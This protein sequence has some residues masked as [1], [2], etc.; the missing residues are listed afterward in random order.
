MSSGSL[1]PICFE[2]RRFRGLK[3]DVGWV[4]DAFGKEPIPT[5]ITASVHDHHE[6]FQG[7]GGLQYESRGEMPLTKKGSEILRSMQEQYGENKGKEVFYA[8]ANKG[9]ISGVHDA[10]ARDLSPG[11]WSVLKR[12]WNEWLSEEEAE[13]EHEE[14]GEDADALSAQGAIKAAKTLKAKGLDESEEAKERHQG[15]LPESTREEI[16]RVGSSARE[17][18]PDSDFLLPSEK[19]YPVKKDG[20]YDRG[21]LLAAARRARM[22]GNEEL[23]N[24]ADRIREREFGSVRE[25]EEDDLSA[26]GAIKAAKTLKAQGKDSMAGDWRNTVE[27]TSDAVSDERGW[28]LIERA[29]WEL[30]TK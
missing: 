9:T 8:S 19:K 18:M 27:L 22:N 26:A 7:D 3:P 15:R 16:G 1:L 12:L 14:P 10:P 24:K 21:L 11:K 2:C 20:K 13:P 23:A 6:P 17:D 5:D 25:E 29:L 28:D 4:C 30:A